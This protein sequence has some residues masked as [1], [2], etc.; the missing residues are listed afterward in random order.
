MVK[1]EGWEEELQGATLSVF[2]CTHC[3]SLV[4]K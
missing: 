2:K 4:L 3:E 1:M